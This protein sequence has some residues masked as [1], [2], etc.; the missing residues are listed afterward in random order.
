MGPSSADGGDEAQVTEG[1]GQEQRWDQWSRAGLQLLDVCGL[2]HI[3]DAAVLTA[4]AVAVEE[5]AP[6]MT[7]QQ[8]V[9]GLQGLAALLHHG[10]AYSRVLA[11][12]V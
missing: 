12:A 2:L 11:R 8:L 5:G 1:A 10:T 9:V 6:G 7:T 3:T 4:L